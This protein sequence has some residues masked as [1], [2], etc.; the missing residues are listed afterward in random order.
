L[1]DRVEEVI[2]FLGMQCGRPAHWRLLDGRAHEDGPGARPDSCA[3]QPA[4][5]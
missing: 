1:R 4:A 5:G 3:A 2:D